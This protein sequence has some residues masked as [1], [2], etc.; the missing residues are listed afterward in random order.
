VK[1]ATTNLLKEMSL[2]NRAVVD[3][4][5]AIVYDDLRAKAGAMFRAER[6][7]HTL[8]PTALV[9]EAYLRLIDQRNMDWKDRAHFCSVAALVMRRILVDHAR[10]KGTERRAIELL[11]RDGVLSITNPDDVLLVDQLIEEL[12]SED[13]NQ[14]KIVE[15]RFFGDLTVEEV[16]GVLGMS[17]RAVEA[18]WTMIRAM[19][20]LKV[21]RP[22]G[23]S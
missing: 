18:E 10:K 7:S 3:D 6:S 11:P 22:A 2:G 17:K 20:R 1:L 23:D 14:A 15:L 16:A 21:G 4:L 13:E 9:H 5:F 19:I 8:Q 12:R